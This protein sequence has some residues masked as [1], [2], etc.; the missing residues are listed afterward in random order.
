MQLCLILIL[1]ISECGTARIFNYTSVRQCPDRFARSFMLPPLTEAWTAMHYINCRSLCEHT[2]NNN[3]SNRL[4]LRRRRVK[5]YSLALSF[6]L[7]PVV[8]FTLVLIASK[9]FCCYSFV[10]RARCYASYSVQLLFSSCWLPFVIFAVIVFATS[11][12]KVL[13]V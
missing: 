8:M 7:S 10:Y 1:V 9:C 13:P 12:H 11:W 4:S 3:A 6:S 5:C 2:V